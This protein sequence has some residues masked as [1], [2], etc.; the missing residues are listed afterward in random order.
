M[1]INNATHQRETLT[2]W[3]TRLPLMRWEAYDP[4]K[5][6]GGMGSPNSKILVC[7]QRW[8]IS[9]IKNCEILALECFLFEF[10]LTFGSKVVV[11]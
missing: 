5:I 6:K 4:F 2:E 10:K 8:D 11:N 3:P 1:F 9:I 7:Y